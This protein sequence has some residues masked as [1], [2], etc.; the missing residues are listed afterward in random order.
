MASI[1]CNKKKVSGIKTSRQMA[2]SKL[3][4]MDPWMKW[5]EISFKVHKAKRLMRLGVHQVGITGVDSLE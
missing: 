3:P 4:F 1:W 5:H 2:K